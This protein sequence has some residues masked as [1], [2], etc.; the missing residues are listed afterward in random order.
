MKM[1]STLTLVITSAVWLGVVQAQAYPPSHYAPLFP[2]NITMKLHHDKPNDNTTFQQL[3]QLTTE[4]F[5]PG[6]PILFHQS[7][8]TTMVPI[9]TNVFFDYAPQVHGILAGLEHRYFGSS[10][11]EGES[12]DNVTDYSPLTLENVLQDGVEF[13]NWIRR[14]VPGAENSPVIYTAGSYGGF[15]AAQARIRHP[16][17]FHAALSTSPILTSFGSSTTAVDNSYKFTASDWL[18][19]VY[20]DQSAE[21]S[22]KIKNALAE[23]ERCIKVSNCQTAIPD[24]N[25]C[26]QPNSTEEWSSLLTHTIMQ[27]Y[28]LI[29][30][31]NYGI[32]VIYDANALQQLINAT[33]AAKTVGE[34]LR[35]PI[36]VGNNAL[37]NAS[38]ADVASVT[39]G[40]SI[41]GEAWKYISCTYLVTS[42]NAVSPSNPLFPAYEV[43]TPSNGCQNPAWEGP[44]YN[45]T[46]EETV[47]YYSLTDRELDSIERLLIV[48][49]S[50]DRTTAVGNPDLSFSA[51]RNH[52]RVIVVEGLAHGDSVISE[53]VYPKGIRT[54]LDEI[55]ETQ[56]N[57]V[58]EWIG[59]TGISSNA[60]S[61]L[62]KRD[63]SVFG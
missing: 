20:L 28:A 1:H 18:A 38:C 9:T 53:S 14:T 57:Y 48:H 58:K 50:N 5:K 47:K 42:E 33:L 40:A 45:W 25:L 2:R 52:S 46:N 26:T 19:Q 51:N 54:Q 39:S 29:P 13:V 62:T 12:W 27:S 63:I 10:F 34:V 37:P 59:F 23:L 8:A 7:E 4:Y 21:A 44:M 35:A 24:L 36:F 3:Y 32:K 41:T 56:L 43:N 16:E 55:R 22:F 17:T 30:Q 49:G 11:P 6:G 31:F 60:T 15:L 61:A